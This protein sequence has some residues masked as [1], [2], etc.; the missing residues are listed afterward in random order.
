[1]EKHG[2]TI[3]IWKLIKT[4]QPKYIYTDNLASYREVLPSEKHVIGK[5][6]TQLIESIN[7]TFCHYLC[8]FRRKTKGYSKS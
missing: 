1:M 7:A 5:K 6:H 2:K 8:R 4:L 3:C